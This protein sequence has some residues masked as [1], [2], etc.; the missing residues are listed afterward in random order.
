VSGGRFRPWA[1]LPTKNWDALLLV[2]NNRS[3]AFYIELGD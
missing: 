1:S 2:E 3:F